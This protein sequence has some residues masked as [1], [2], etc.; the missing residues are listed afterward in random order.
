MRKTFLALII[1]V[2]TASAMAT[3]GTLI[4]GEQARAT[5]STSAKSVASLG[6][7]T[8]VDIL[9]RRGGWLQVKVQDKVGWVRLLSVRSG[10][11]GS[12]NSA[13]E[14][15]GVVGLATKR[16]SNQVVAVAGLRG[17]NEEDLKSAHFNAAELGELDTFKTNRP[18]AESFAK[19]GQ[20]YP[21]SVAYLNPPPQNTA[22]ATNRWE[23]VLP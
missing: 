18:Q 9:N 2:W 21:H 22:P 20:L 1:S 8:P 6:S 5:P 19:Q 7:G 10:T 15:G 13:A 3:S 12:A 14:L 17:L 16:N 11:S 4:R 23:G